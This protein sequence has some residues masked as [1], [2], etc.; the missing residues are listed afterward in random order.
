MNRPVRRLATV[1]LAMLGLLALNVTYIQVVA[2]SEYRGDPRNPRLAADRAS[3]ER[4]PIVTREGLVVADSDRVPGSAITFQR[5]YP[6][7]ELFG[8]V[9]GYSTLLFGDTGIEQTRARTLRSGS[10]LT[11]SGII[12]ALLGRE[13]ESEGVRLTLSGPVQRAAAEALGEQPGA[14]VAL[15]PTTGE[16]LALFS[17]PSFDPNL[18]LGG[19][20]DA[21]DR[22]AADPTE[23]LRNR[24]LA[25]RYAPGSAFKLITAAAALEAG[26]ASPDTAFPD[27]E[28][29]P[30]PGSTAVIRNADRGV[31]ADGTSVTLSVAFARSCNTVFAEIG[32]TLG[33]A[34]L[35]ETAEAFGFNRPPDFELPVVESVVPA[36]ADAAAAAQSAIGQRSVQAT[37]LQMAL[38]AGTVA[39]EGRLMLPH[40]VSETF[41]KDLTIT[42]STRS[43]EVRRAL[44]PGTA[45]ALSRMMEQAVETGTGRAAAIPGVTV[46]G[47]TGT[48]QVPGEA[49]HA[50]FVGYA[51]GDSRSIAVAVFVEN[52]GTIGSD[53]TG[54]TV[55]APIARQVME[56]WLDA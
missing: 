8:H 44:S 49:P 16:I 22:L 25:D 42:S 32:A 41:D 50:W 39:N 19:S 18:L 35:A 37:V 11:I 30:L 40:V 48:A 14:V 27:V 26:L 46:G 5:R 53:A 55:A 36:E 31:C 20:P 43:I 21:G 56:S 12:D 9:V 2:A 28:A 1:L 52:G 38:V 4:G 34:V 10:D 51:L 15:D 24:A 17:S 7:D 45:A 23:P 13:R 54:G 33:G 6:N 47:K 3:T 29:Y